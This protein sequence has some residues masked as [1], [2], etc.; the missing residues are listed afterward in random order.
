MKNYTPSNSTDG[1]EFMAK[2]CDNCYKV[3]Q[4]TILTNA[5]IGNDVKQWDY[6]ENDMPVCTS[7][8]AERP[9]KKVNQSNE[10]SLF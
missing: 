3:N 5:L 10:N 9:K 4:C 8:K 7:F 2:Y 6:D 1:M